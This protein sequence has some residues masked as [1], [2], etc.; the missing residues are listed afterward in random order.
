MKTFNKIL[1]I[2]LIIV[3]ASFAAF[4]IAES[5]IISD[6]KKLPLVKLDFTQIENGQ[7]FGNYQIFPVKVSVQVTIQNGTITQIELLEHFNGKGSA[8]EKIMDDI[9]REQSLQVDCISGATV[10]S[11]A[12]KKAVEDSLL[13]E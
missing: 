3:A 4:K 8:A 5:K 12:I 7:Y 1:I 10:S 2:L 9:I 11:M 6:A 13:G